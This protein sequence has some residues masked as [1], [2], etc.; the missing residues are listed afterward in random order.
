[1]GMSADEYWNGDAEA[2]V[3]Y[4]KAYRE[5]LKFEDMMLWRQGMY[6]YHALCKVAPALN[7]IKPREPLEYI[8]PFGF[9]FD[10]NKKEEEEK[11]TV[12]KGFEYMK[13]WADSFNQKRKQNGNKRSSA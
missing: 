12:D 13:A 11:P 4:R 10:F 9:D 7:A 1:M 2:C 5:R 8:K 3:A 6:V